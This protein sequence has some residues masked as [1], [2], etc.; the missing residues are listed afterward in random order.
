[1]NQYKILRRTWQGMF[2]RCYNQDNPNYK[3]YGARGIEIS[4]RWLNFELFFADMAPKPSPKLSV[5]RIDN[6]GPYSRENCK[7][8]TAHEPSLNRRPPQFNPRSKVWTIE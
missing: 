6:N 1:M 7:W 2:S 8:A 4:P 5:E 3:N